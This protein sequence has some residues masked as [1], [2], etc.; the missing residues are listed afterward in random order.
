MILTFF[1]DKLCI[2]KNGE[3]I[4]YNSV[5]IDSVYILCDCTSSCKIAHCRFSFDQIKSKIARDFIQQSNLETTR[6]IDE[7]HRCIGSV[8]ARP[9]FNVV[10]STTA[11]YMLMHKKIYHKKYL[12]HLLRTCCK[13]L[14]IKNYV[15]HERK[16][17][18]FVIGEIGKKNVHKKFVCI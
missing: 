14:R 5:L 7:I 8:L 18:V 9:E 11:S 6:C 15:G 4:C 12:G 17:R 3:M 13:Y 16:K 2:L 1:H 10:H